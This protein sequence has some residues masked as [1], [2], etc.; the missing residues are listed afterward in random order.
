MRQHDQVAQAAVTHLHRARLVCC[1]DETCRYYPNCGLL[2][3]HQD[4]V[5][6]LLTAIYSE[7]APTVIGNDYL[8]IG[9]VERK[10]WREGIHQPQSSVEMRQAVL[11]FKEYREVQMSPGGW[12][13]EEPSE[14]S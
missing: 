4:E 10:A 6:A 2:I 5:E 8:V 14:L 9:T 3:A 13:P 11:D 1:L 12:F 7:R